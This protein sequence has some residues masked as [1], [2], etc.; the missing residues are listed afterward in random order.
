MDDKEVLM[1][2]FKI[3]A[4]IQDNYNTLFWH[5]TNVFFV[6]NSALFAAYGLTATKIL[7]VG[8]LGTGTPE[9]F[10][11]VLIPISLAL[12]FIGVFGALL[13]KLWLNIH[14]RA[15]FLQ[16]HWRER[17]KILEDE[18]GKGSMIFDEF[19]MS[20]DKKYEAKFGLVRNKKKM[21]LDFLNG[22]GLTR[23]GRSDEKHKKGVQQRTPKGLREI[24]DQVFLSFIVI[25]ICLSLLGIA[26]VVWS[27]P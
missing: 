2:K 1:E 8:K 16:N 5:R 15:S 22:L 14:R 23:E 12:V 26:I 11:F 10:A 13:S 18:I 3:A 9:E 17:A 27:L 21:L 25:W 7:E 4:H 6:I 20:E 24:L 19:R